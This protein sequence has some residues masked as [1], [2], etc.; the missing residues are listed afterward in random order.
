MNIRP[1]SAISLLLPLFAGALTVLAF[2]P[3]GYWPIQLLSLALVFH[4][5]L[6]AQSVRKSVFIGWVYGFGWAVCGV[7]WL[8]VSMHRFGG[9]PAWLAVLAVLLLGLGVG[10]FAALALG[11]GIWLRQRWSSPAALGALLILPACWTLTEWLR[12]WVFTGFPWL[13]SGYAH[14]GSPLA[15][16][17][18]LGGVFGVGLLAAIA[19]GCLAYLPFRQTRGRILAVLLLIIVFAGGFVLHHVH[20]TEPNGQPISVRLL[21]TNVSQEMK[22]ARAQIEAMLA[23]NYGMITEQH[24]DLIATPETA[25]PVM[26]QRLPPKYLSQ[27]ATFAQMTGSHLLLGIPIFDGATDYTNS[28]IGL[29]P[30][31]LSQPD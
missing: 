22:F 12:G 16:F 1:S 23:L 11:V 19:A 31:T 30:H 5:A 9:M 7:Y 17:A 2:A 28:M 25:V 14:T 26:A 4:L 6:R 10:V 8:F 21:Q 27:L 20:W 13:V 24:A 15:G 18:P 3:F 29:T